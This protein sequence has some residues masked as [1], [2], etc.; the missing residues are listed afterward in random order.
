MSSNIR[1]IRRSIGS[2]SRKGVQ[3][4]S[5]VMVSPPISLT[6]SIFDPAVG[7]RIGGPADPWCGELRNC[8]ML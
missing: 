4:M 7:K 3:R 8:S 5:V 6:T 1:L 2:S